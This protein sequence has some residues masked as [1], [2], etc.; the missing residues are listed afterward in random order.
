MLAY[1]HKRNKGGR[2]D[3]HDTATIS[4]MTDSGAVPHMVK[5][6]SSSAL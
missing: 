1:V 6:S 3:K 4:M 2:K 5:S